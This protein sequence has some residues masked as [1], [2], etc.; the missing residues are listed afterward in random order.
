MPTD[1]RI[2]P[3][4]GNEFNLPVPS[5]STYEIYKTNF[6]WNVPDNQ[7]IGNIPIS[8]EAD[9]DEVNTADANPTNDFAII[10]LFVGRLPTPE[11]NHV[12][13][14]TKVEVFINAS[15]S[16]DEDG[17]N[18]SCIFDIPYDDGSRSWAYIEVVS[19]SCQTNWTW[20]DDGD[21]PILVTVVDE[22]RDEVE[23]ILYANITNRAPLLEIRSMR[24]EAR[25]EH[26]ITLYA[27]ANDTDS[28][29]VFPGVVDVFWPDAQCA[30]G[31]Y[32]K[33]CTTTA[34]TEG[35][36]TFKAVGVDDDLAQTEAF[37]DILFTNIAPHSTIINLYE[38]GGIIESDEQQIWQLDED[39]MVTIK[40]QAEDSIDDIN[41]LDHTWWPDN[42]QPNLIYFLEGRVTEF[43]MSWQTSG[44][45]TIRLD[46]TDNDGATSST[47]ERWVNIRNVPPVVQPLD[48]ILPIAEGQSVT[49]TGNST[50]TPSDLP[51]L[52]KCWDV[53]P[54]ID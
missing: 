14:Q 43:D 34:P 22:E 12:T 16:F 9:P 13:E 48:T 17:G 36:H 32:T 25:V 40:G 18:V 52:T 6:T 44:L 42:R 45:H 23:T 50:D 3:P 41:S 27:F 15:S 10:E 37:I 53:D 31:Y 11:I 49:I 7:P 19:L 29:D 5:L 47:N 51:S 35:Y 4:T 1:L 38:N 21:Y 28:E 46:V 33:T 26:P 39:Q 20:V 54:G 2:Y 8:W 24:S 30:E